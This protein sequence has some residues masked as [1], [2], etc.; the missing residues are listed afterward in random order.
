MNKFIIKKIF[1]SLGKRVSP[2]YCIFIDNKLQA[3]TRKIA[4]TFSLL[5]KF[6]F[7]P[8]VKLK[9]S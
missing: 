2:S 1:T 5:D 7:F 8:G 3:I 9:T 6:P 4:I